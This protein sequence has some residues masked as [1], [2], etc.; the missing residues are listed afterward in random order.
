MRSAD[1][2]GSIG[3]GE[4]NSLDRLL[5]S[6]LSETSARCAAVMD[7]SGRLLVARG[8]TSELDQVSFASLAAADF[9]ASDQLATLLGE[10]EFSSLYHHGQRRSIFLADV[11][12]I[13]ILAALFDNR[14]TLG[15]VRIKT[16][17][18]M[19]EFASVFEALA[20][21][22]PGAAGRPFEAGWVE[23]AEDEIDRLFSE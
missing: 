5:N 16:K 2:I 6:F 8:D 23:E 18:L 20:A 11:A 9:A 13:A 7:R 21:Q 12:G 4:L 22:T 3:P 15:M 10:E 17:S 1:N 19:P 14:T